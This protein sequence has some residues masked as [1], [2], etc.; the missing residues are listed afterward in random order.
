MA[1]RS[2]ISKNIAESASTYVGVDGELIVDT[3]SN[4]LKISNGSTGG[5]VSLNRSV[6]TYGDDSSVAI[7]LTKDVAILNGGSSSGG[8]SLMNY[9]LADGTYTG[10]RIYM[11]RGT[12]T[13]TSLNV[14]FSKLNKNG[15]I[16]TNQSNEVF[17]Q[18][19]STNTCIWN[20]SAW[21]LSWD[22]RA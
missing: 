8:D 1:T 21:N 13:R 10:Q 14:I 18:F 16:Q 9:T 20:G 2:I 5:G 17:G 7:D 3:T 12:G 4:T 11:V 6:S 22:G 15:A 19:E